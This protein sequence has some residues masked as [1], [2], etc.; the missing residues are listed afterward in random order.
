MESKQPLWVTMAYS[1]LVEKRKR[2]IDSNTSLAVH[3]F[4][5]VRGWLRDQSKQWRACWRSPVTHTWLSS[6]TEPLPCPGVTSAQL[7]DIPQPRKPFTPGWPHLIGFREKDKEWKEKQKSDYDK[8]DREKVVF[9]SQWVLKVY[10]VNCIMHCMLV[11]GAGIRIHIHNCTHVSDAII[12]EHRH[13]PTNQLLCHLLD[14]LQAVVWVCGTAA[15]QSHQAPHPCQCS[16]GVRV[17]F[18]SERGLS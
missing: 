17:P 3:T 14:N 5:R 7:T 2:R 15:H 11:C 9:E 13:Q 12:S 4:P 8:C 18:Q 16:S 6:T 10:K 1:M